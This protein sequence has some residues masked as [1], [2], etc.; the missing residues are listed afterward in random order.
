[1]KIDTSP[2]VK[3]LLR[4]NLTGITGTLVS[5]SLSLFTAS[6]HSQGYD[7]RGVADTTWNEATVTYATAPLIG[8]VAA[9]AGPFASGVWAEADVT[10][11]TT[12]NRL[13]SMAISGK[14]GTSA[15][16]WSKE[17]STNRPQLVVTVRP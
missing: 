2:D 17:N 11:V 9:S 13:V 7:V 1:L 15:Q 12:P 5:A 16:F 4:F 3:S 10:S 6:A 14:N 8:I